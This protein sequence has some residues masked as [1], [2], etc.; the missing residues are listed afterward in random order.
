MRLKNVE[1]KA[2]KT[3]LGKR[4]DVESFQGNVEDLFKNAVFVRLHTGL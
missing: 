1:H 4:T 3:W 2:M